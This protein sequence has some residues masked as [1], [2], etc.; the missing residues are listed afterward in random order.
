MNILLFSD[1]HINK[2]DLPECQSILEEI[3][4][5][6]EQYQID[7]VIDLGDT[8]NGLSPSSQEL[9][10]FSDFVNKLNRKI[11][12]LA[13]QSHESENFEHSILNHFGILKKDTITILKEYHDDNHLFCGHFIVKESKKNFGATISK[14]ELK[15]KYIF[16]GH[17]HSFEIIKPNICQL[18]SVRFVDFAESE[19]KQ[20]VVAIIEN[21]GEKEEKVQFIPLKNPYPMIEYILG[22]NS[23]EIN[24]LD[25]VNENTPIKDPIEVKKVVPGASGE[26]I[27]PLNDPVGQLIVQLDQTDPKTKIRIIY[28]NYE[29]W[30]TFLPFQQKYKEKFVKFID[31]KEFIISANSQKREDKETVNLLELLNSWLEKNQIPEAIKKVLKEEISGA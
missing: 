25:K 15:Y 14:S 22:D 4:S 12:I 30:R 23:N 7:Q 29:L 17:S 24:E 16:L 10:T 2:Q 28:K 18:G 31:K 3:L 9:D 5:L 27:A 19:D 6:C 11:I 20:K 13:A 21:Y 26:Q 1:I 8:F